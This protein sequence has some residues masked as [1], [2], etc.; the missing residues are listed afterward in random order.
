[1]ALWLM[2][3]PTSV[4]RIAFWEIYQP[5][6]QPHEPHPKWGTLVLS[7]LSPP[8]LMS[9]RPGSCQS[10]TYETPPK[11]L[12]AMLYQR[13]SSQIASNPVVHLGPLLPPQPGS[14]AL[15]PPLPALGTVPQTPL[16]GP[17]WPGPNHLNDL[18]V[19][20]F[21]QSPGKEICFHNLHSFGAFASCLSSRLYIKAVFLGPARWSSG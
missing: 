6:L 18:L 11:V 10:Q 5:G 21:L 17:C 4:V 3:Y 2:D 20:Y 15:L 9:D 1:M 13:R 14:R 19:P 16:Q 8:R 12:G 7:S